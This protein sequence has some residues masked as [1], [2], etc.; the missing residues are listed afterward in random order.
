[1]SAP[2]LSVRA[3]VPERDV[4][5]ELTVPAGRV[6]A[7]LGPNGAGKSTVLGLAAGTVRPADG[8]VHVAGRR[9][10]GEGAW[11]PPHGR[12]ISLL[13]QE[14]LLLPHLDVLANVAFGPRAR[15]VAR[16]AA[17]E[18]ARTRLAEVGA[19][20][21]AERRVHRL[22]GGQAQRVALA[23]ALAPDPHLLL[24]DEPLSALDV[25]AAAQL[26]QVLRAA[27]RGSGRAAVVVT[28]DLLDVL[29]LADDVVVLEAGR[30]VEQGTTAEVLGRP[31]SG[32]GARL[33][34]VNLLLGE[35]VAADAVRAGDEVVHGLASAQPAARTGRAAA[36]FS[37]RAVAVH[38]TAPGG[39]P[40]NVLPVRVTGLEQQ[41]ALVRVRGET[42]SG[43]RLAADVTPASLSV[44]RVGVGD[45]V[46]LVVKAAEVEIYDA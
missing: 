18:V 17:D 45:D 23:R 29:A 28:H 37:P 27:L 35:R 2:A 36:A 9:V 30:V 20:A 1:M 10:A 3:A 38:R 46:V 13:A 31:R 32:F 41:G 25:D 12:R 15:G 16:R 24:L 34:G 44:L 19:E 4:E 5:I 8:E 40:R 39:S 26:R 33:A 14:P 43:T 6:L 42:A 11:V 21:L 22:S 7:L